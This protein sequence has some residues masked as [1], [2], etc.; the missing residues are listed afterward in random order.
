MTADAN[1]CPYVGLQP[2]TEED[3][4]YFFGRERE[5]RFVGAN[6]YAAKLT[7]LYGE[8]G[9]GK[10]SVL[11]AGVV[12]ELRAEAAHRRRD[13]SRLAA[14]RCA[15]DPQGRVAHAGDEA[16]GK[17]LGLDAGTPLDDLLAAAGKAIGGTTLVL[18]DQ[19]E[20][21]FLYYPAGGAG[22]EF[23]AELA[24]AVNRRDVNA[25]FVLSIREDSLSKLDR[26][27]ARI[28]TVLA[29]PL[30]IRHLRP[31]MRGMRSANRSTC[32]TSGRTRPRSR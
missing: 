25:G 17:P 4:A 29:N 15:V 22:D 23:D 32:T 31:R 26:F 6:L 12:P 11:M 10:S 3:R 9:V 30:R 5:I 20:E 19:F 28:P 16:A 14:A 2:F 13:L 7:V 1:F 24:R 21:Y 27:R 8:S 18:M